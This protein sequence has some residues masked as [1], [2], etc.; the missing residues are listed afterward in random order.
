MKSKIALSCFVVVSLF[1]AAMPAMAGVVTM[2]FSNAGSNNYYG[3]PSFP[4]SLSV[5]GGP[6]QNMMCIGYNEHI[7]GGET[8]LANA[9]SVGSLDPSTHLLDYQAAFLFTLAVQ[10][11]GVNGTANAAAWYLLEGAPALDS[12]AAA[13][14]SLAQSRTYY[15]GE[16]SNITLYIAIPGTESGSDGTPQNFLATPEPTTLGLLGTGIL[17]FSAFLRRKV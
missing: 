13:L 4:Y 7:Y 3:T 5:N 15:Q 8:W 11:G 2:T 10:S 1:V 16:F 14:L 12:A 17:G 9:V 6:L